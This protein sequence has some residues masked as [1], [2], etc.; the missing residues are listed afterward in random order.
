MSRAMELYN[1]F[2]DEEDNEQDI[3]QVVMCS[4]QQVQY[5]CS[6]SDNECSDNEDEYDPY[7][8]NGVQLSDMEAYDGFAE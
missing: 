4:V 6:Y 7:P 1:G 3:Q 2:A 8:S 5:L